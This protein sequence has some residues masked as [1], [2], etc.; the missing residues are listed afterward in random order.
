MKFYNYNLCNQTNLLWFKL[1]F[2]TFLVDT[3]T[4]SCCI[5]ISFLKLLNTSLDHQRFHFLSLYAPNIIITPPHAYMYHFNIGAA[6]VFHATSP[7][8]SKERPNVIL[9][10]QMTN[11]NLVLI[12]S[13]AKPRYSA[14]SIF[15]VERCISSWSRSTTTHGISYPSESSKSFVIAHVFATFFHLVSFK[16]I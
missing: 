14:G 11:Q 1:C 8:V 4:L 15:S 3:C 10:C 6:S 5:N 16:N 9:V 2:S 7:R 13:T 12:L